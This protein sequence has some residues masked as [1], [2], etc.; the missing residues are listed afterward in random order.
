VETLEAAIAIESKKDFA[1]I[2]VQDL[3][4][5]DKTNDGCMKEGKSSPLKAW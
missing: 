2:S 1:K 4:D 5:C 3:I